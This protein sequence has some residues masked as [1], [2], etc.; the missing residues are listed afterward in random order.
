MKKINLFEPNLSDL[1]K[2]FVLEALNKNQ[3]SSYGYFNDLLEKEVKKITGSKY[4][5][6]ISS[7]SAALYTA[8]RSAGIKKDEIVITQSY[9]FSATTNAIMLNNSIPLLVDISDKDLNI[10]FENLKE[11]FKK[12]TFRKNNATF[13]K[14][15]K[16]KLPVY[17]WYSL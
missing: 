4:N 8:F 17:V 9:T 13:H 16:K 12:E 1:E 7:G 15:A 3:I 5:L 11:F 2:K 6:T 10:D 14:K